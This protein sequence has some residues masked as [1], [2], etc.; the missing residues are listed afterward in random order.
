MKTIRRL[1]KWCKEWLR[2]YRGG[3]IRD[4]FKLSSGF[5]IET[6][7]DVKLLAVKKQKEFK[8][9]YLIN[10]VLCEYNVYQ[11]SQDWLDDMYS[12]TLT[13]KRKKHENNKHTK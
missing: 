5:S 1:I 4:V 12:I 2:I 10:I 9:K 6:L 7:E 8:K 13:Y 3:T 11:G